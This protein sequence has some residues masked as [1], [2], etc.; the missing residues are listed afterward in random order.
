ME[1]QEGKQTQEEQNKSA[2]MAP[3][4]PTHTTYKAHTTLHIHDVA[5]FSL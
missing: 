3:L 1:T 5:W 2:A 4:S